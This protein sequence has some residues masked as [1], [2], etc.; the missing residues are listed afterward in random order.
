MVP[1]PL[2]SQGLFSTAVASSEWPQ[3]NSPLYALWP[4]CLAEAKEGSAEPVS[5]GAGGAGRAGASK[6]CGHKM[7]VGR[8]RLVYLA[9]CFQAS[10]AP[11]WGDTH[12]A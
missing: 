7:G 11:S 12:I 5:V 1:H 6:P 8:G 9:A 10:V 4:G 3:G 2:L